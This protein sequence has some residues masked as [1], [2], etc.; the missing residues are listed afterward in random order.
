MTRVRARLF[1]TGAGVLVGLL[2]GATIGL[3]Y[4]VFKEA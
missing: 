1:G 2:V 3:G 4:A